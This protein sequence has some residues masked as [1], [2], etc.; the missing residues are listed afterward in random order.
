MVE[1]RTFK[2]EEFTQPKRLLSVYDR[3]AQIISVHTSFGNIPNKFMLQIAEITEFLLTIVFI[4]CHRKKDY[5]PVCAFSTMAHQKDDE[6]SVRI[7]KN[8]KNVIS[9]TDLKYVL[10]LL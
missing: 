3:P 6:Y 9:T 7:R 4:C 1:E 2:N 8:I 10:I 5:R